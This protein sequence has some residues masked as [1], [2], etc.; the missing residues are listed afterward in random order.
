[1][2]LISVLFSIF[3]LSF[4]NLLADADNNFI[5]WKI[6]FKKLALSK[7]I[8]EQTF[9]NVMSKAKYLPKVIEYDRY[10]PEFYEDTKT[11]VSKR[12]SFSVNG[13]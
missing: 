6:N 11:Y 7:D 12:T 9:N 13:Y 1:M 8:S 10:Q 4:S 2:K 3:F 5:E